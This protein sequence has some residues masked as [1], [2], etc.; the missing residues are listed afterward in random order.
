MPPRGS[1][2]I[3]EK[4]C[5][6][7]AGIDELQLHK[8]LG[9]AMSANHF[10]ALL[11]TLISFIASNLTPLSRR[12]SAVAQH[13]GRY[14][15]GSQQSDTLIHLKARATVQEIKEQIIPELTDAPTR[16]THKSFL[17]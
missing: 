14:P 8:P 2:R 12:V 11:A 3:D 7:S 5:Y 13:P 16:E 9:R 6:A 1:I 10:P 4:N 17:I 15:G